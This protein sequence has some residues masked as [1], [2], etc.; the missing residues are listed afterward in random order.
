MA[1]RYRVR[2]CGITVRQH[3]FGRLRSRQRRVVI[4][5]IGAVEKNIAL[6]V[7]PQRAQTSS[8][9]SGLLHP[10]YWQRPADLPHRRTLTVSEIPVT[11]ML[12]RFHA[13]NGSVIPLKE[14]PHCSRSKSS[15]QNQSNR[16]RHRLGDRGSFT[17]MVTILVTV[18]PK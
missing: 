4:A 16:Q 5:R 3:G 6:T 14:W 18:A 15:L 8:C 11:D 2:F 17:P 1:Q 12:A 7:G 10:S 13:I 9:Q